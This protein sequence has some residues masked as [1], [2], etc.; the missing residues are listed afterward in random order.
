MV[1]VGITSYSLSRAVNSEKISV[2]EAIRFAAEHGA[3]HFE[4]SASGKLVLNGNDE[5]AELVKKEVR[6]AGMVI[7]SYTIGANFVKPDM[8]A[9]RN[10]IARVKS[11]VEIAA[12][13]GAT[14]M[15]HDCASRPLEENTQ[16]NFEKDFPLLVDAC[17]E[18]ADHAAKYGITT[19][20]ENHG[21]YM[22][23]SE[24]VRRLVVS[25]GRTNFRTTLDVG[26]FLC[27]DEDPVSAVMN[28][29][30]YA[31]MI[32]FKD[33][34]IR[35]Q[36]T[37]PPD[38]AGYIKTLHNKYIRGAITGDGD[39]DLDTIAKLIKEANYDGFLSVEFEGWE[40]CMEGTARA[41]KN[42]LA[43]FERN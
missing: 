16:E 10:E 19:S 33:F 15:R 40:D 27:V 38:G 11:E 37:P 12:K 2:P 21:F 5:L 25:V 41:L 29:L 6:D 26:N 18:I 35:R 1:T 23:N 13:M 42:V 8:E 39:V 32:H 22:Q 3:K 30:P 9:Y 28:N 20:V 36:S 14:R 24:R 31:S 43:I 34:H 17:G 4:I 7:S